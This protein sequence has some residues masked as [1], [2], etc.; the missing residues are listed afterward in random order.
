ME[1]LATTPNPAPAPPLPEMPPRNK[2]NYIII[3]V[4]FVLVLLGI[5]PLLLN[6]MHTQP[7]VV[8]PTPTT[9]VIILTPTLTLVPDSALTE[10][11]K[12][13]ITEQIKPDLKK[14]VTIDYTVSKVKAYGTDWAMLQIVNPTT[15][16]AI[17]VVKKENDR[18]TIKLGPGTYFD[19]ESLNEIEAPQSLIHDI[20]KPL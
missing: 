13:V 10:Q 19:E 15:D 1:E 9:A 12:A 18:W 11:E 8:T 7:P 17:V 5:T 16:P 2:K 6:S 4:C 20:D 3:A 14:L